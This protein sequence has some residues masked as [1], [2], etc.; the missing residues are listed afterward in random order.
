MFDWTDGVTLIAVILFLVVLHWL[1]PCFLLE[2]D[3]QGRD[4]CER[5]GAF[6]FKD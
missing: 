1:C 4:V 3:W 6:R 2:H 5:C